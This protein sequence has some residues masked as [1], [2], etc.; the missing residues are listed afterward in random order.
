ML[1]RATMLR[2]LEDKRRSALL[3]IKMIR[4]DALYRHNQST[5]CEF[6]GLE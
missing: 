6:T 5:E 4:S 1:L 3:A 2:R